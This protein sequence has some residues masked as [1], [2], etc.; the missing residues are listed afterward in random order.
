MDWPSVKSKR[1]PD[2]GLDEGRLEENEA[3][4]VF[5]STMVGTCCYMQVL[6]SWTILFK[7]CTHVVSTRL[8]PAHA[9]YGVEDLENR[10]PSSR[11]IDQHRR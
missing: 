2:D 7:H 10:W 11:L 4:A 8:R 3:G 1:L 5:G 9:M 6:V